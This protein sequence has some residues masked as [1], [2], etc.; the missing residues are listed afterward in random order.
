MEETKSIP[1]VEGNPGKPT[2]SVVSFF[3]EMLSVGDLLAYTI[4]SSREEVVWDTYE[5]KIVRTIKGPILNP[6]EKL[7]EDRRF[8]LED[9]K[10]HSRYILSTSSEGG[11]FDSDG[12]N[13]IYHNSLITKLSEN[14]GS[15][16]TR[17][18]L[19]VLIAPKE[20]ESNETTKLR[21]Y[22]ETGQ[23]SSSGGF[24]LEGETDELFDRAMEFLRS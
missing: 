7:E 16:E 10:T 3:Q 9:F 23:F 18:G 24:T 11:T 6:T 20:G 1:R 12:E 13:T 17:E 5:E 4:E 21:I 22:Y 8:I 19:L 2:Y 14:V 15:R